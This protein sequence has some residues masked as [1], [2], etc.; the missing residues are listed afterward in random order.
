MNAQTRR[1]FAALTLCLP[2]LPAMALPK[3]SLSWVQQNGSSAQG[4]AID[5]WVRLSV[6]P[7]ESQPLVLNGTT[8][9][10]SAEDL[11]SFSS[12]SEVLQSGWMEFSCAGPG[13][14]FGDCNAAPQWTLKFNED[15]ATSF[16]VPMNLTMAPGESRDFL[17][18]TFTPVAGALTAG[19]YFL[20]SAALTLY[21]RGRDSVGEEHFELFDLGVTCIGAADACAFTRTITATV[22]EPASYGLMLLGMAALGLSRRM[23]RQGSP[24]SSRDQ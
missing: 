5:V 7:A 10:F 15:P 3:T 9:S 18:A 19:T 20:S 1:L 4:S 23:H 16:F 14:S 11:A 2:V 12:V 13:R 17:M 24:R 21:P 8:A 6:D 22:P